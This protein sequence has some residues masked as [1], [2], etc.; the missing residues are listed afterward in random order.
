MDVILAVFL[1]I[2]AIGVFFYA[3]KEKT[4]GMNNE[5][6]ERQIAARGK[7]Y[8]V[9]F[10]TALIGFAVLILLDVAE[11]SIPLMDTAKYIILLFISLGTF[12]VYCIMKDAYVGLH[13]K[14]RS[15]II[16][17]LIIMVFETY[18]A[19]RDIMEG[20][21]VKDGMI[22]DS[23]ITIAMVILLLVITSAMLI[24]NSQ[25]KKREAEEDEES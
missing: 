16:L 10:F 22:T 1:C 9:G 3:S 15:N 13:T 4:G 25:I 7:G 20:E 5:Y 18:Q 23:V 21:M 24:R 14:C 19:V 6:D 12:V 11:I 2:T 17:W 8:K